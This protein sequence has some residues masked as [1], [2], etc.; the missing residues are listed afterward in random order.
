MTSHDGDTEGRDQRLDEV[1]TA[2][3]EAVD[4]GQ[5]PAP[6]E[7]LARYPDLAPEL[8]AFFAAQAHLERM[9]APHRPALRASDITADLTVAPD[10]QAIAAA[11]GTVRYFGDY[12]LL[13]EIARGG[14]GVVYRARQVSLNRTVALKMILAG[15]FASEADVRRFKTEAE[16][17]AN[18][19][20]PNIVPIYEV[21][22]YQGQHYFSMKLIEGGNLA[23]ERESA[24]A[25]LRSAARLIVAVAGAVH[26][27]HQRGIL[28]RDLKPAN[29]LIDRAG[30]PHV[31]DFG[32]AKRVEGGQDLTQSGAILG[33]PSYMAPEQAAGKRGLSTAAD[34]YSLGAILYE[35]LTGRPPF[36]ADTPLDTVLQVLHEE[37][38]RPRSLNAAVPRDLETTCL[39]CLQKDPQRRYGSAEALA[40]DLQRW[41]AGE[42][43]AARPVGRWERAR[44][45]VR[46]RP[47]AAALIAVSI[48][49]SLTLLVGGVAY[50]WRLESALADARN[51]RTQVEERELTVRGQL[52]D[53]DVRAMQEAW[54]KGNTA[55]V[56]ELLK[57]HR[58]LR[59][60]TNGQWFEQPDVRSFEWYL[61]WGLCRD[62]VLRLPCGGAR[63]VAYAPD[64]K[65]LVTAGDKLMDI[66]PKEAGAGHAL[67]CICLWNAHNGERLEV[68]GI[69]QDRVTHL[70]FSPDGKAI[71]AAIGK[72]V[73]VYGPQLRNEIA[74][75]PQPNW[76]C[77]LAFARDRPEQL[78]VALQGPKGVGGEVR[79]INLR[80]RASVSVFTDPNK[81]PQVIDLSADGATLAVGTGNR[82][83]L[84]RTAGGV[85]HRDLLFNGTHTLALS[86]DGKLLALWR[87]SATVLI[88]VATGKE[89][90]QLAIKETTWAGNNL[91]FAPDGKT[92]ALSGHTMVQLWDVESRKEKALFKGPAHAITA[93]AF[94]PDGT[95]LAAAVH[96]SDEVRIW[97]VAAPPGPESIALQNHHFP[98]LA[99]APDGKTLIVRCPKA[100]RRFR[101]MPE[102]PDS[103]L[104]FETRPPLEARRNTVNVFYATASPESY[105]LCSDSVNLR[106]VAYA[107]DGK[108]VAV[109]GDR[110]AKSVQ[111]WDAVT[112][113]S[114]QTLK[115]DTPCY[116]VAFSPD[117]KTLATLGLDR[118]VTLWNTGAWTERAV[119]AGHPRWIDGLAFTA[120]GA[121]LATAGNDGTVKL[122]DVAAGKER[123]TLPRQ[124]TRLDVLLFSPDSRV[125]VTG[126]KPDEGGG[127]I[128]LWDPATGKELGRVDG[129]YSTQQNIA[130]S[131][132]GTRLAVVAFDNMAKQYAIKLCDGRTGAVRA[133]FAAHNW[134]IPGLAF[135][136]GGKTL[137]TGSWDQT[138]KVWDVPGGKLRKSLP[139]PGWVE[140][141]A[142]SPDGATLIAGG[143][144]GTAR[145]WDTADYH[146]RAVLDKAGDQSVARLALSA[147]GAT[148][149][150]AGLNG[151]GMKAW[152]VADG[153][154]RAALAVETGAM[155]PP[156]F[157]PDGQTLVID[158][159]NTVRL[160]D[161]E[162][163]KE[164]KLPTPAQQQ[165][166]LFVLAATPD[167]HNVLS[168]RSGE[169]TATLWDA[170]AHKERARLDGFT[171]PISRAAFTRDGRLLA[172]G[173]DDG[174]INLWDG[175]TGKWQQALH[176]H[177]GS[178][179]TDLTFT[180]DGSVL[181]S[182]SWDGTIRLWDPA[183]RE[184]LVN[185]KATKGVVKLALAPTGPLLAGVEHD[186]AV[187]L[188]DR[189][190]QQY[191]GTLRKD[192]SAASGQVEAIGF[193]P[194]GRT[195]A[196]CQ[197]NVLKLW[198]PA[199]GLERL[200]LWDAQMQIR[201]FAFAPDG[202]TLAAATD[203][204]VRLWHAAS[205]READW[206]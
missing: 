156:I 115:R 76:V 133:A 12:E 47:A 62:G 166:S 106:R 17:A 195:L 82:V 72:E 169:K 42:P 27:A 180:D 148:L 37:P 157:A 61:F 53:Y 13:E 160:W 117:G 175:P 124:P 83:V 147:D 159:Y 105:T 145:L 165:H 100:S 91:T 150:T 95:R 4:A 79:L 78:A 205:A 109:A 185:L 192:P 85:N 120:D 196:T 102:R 90:G 125:L 15:Q 149:I 190:R 202:K 43:I 1:A 139:G 18:L 158:S 135:A 23:A 14:M 113:Q 118:C 130:F 63:L 48:V 189:E 64:G 58:P 123:V 55:R 11:L 67:E 179:V 129:S 22:E 69:P 57:A 206:K 10:K 86:P 35:L 75:L 6:D 56:H 187:H 65:T 28:H 173:H 199:T 31:T 3:L 177:D 74:R 24:R 92:L 66:R 126:L 112:G 97:D 54:D 176:G 41:L 29:I 71:A 127:T 52:Y 170:P 45:W 98:A 33:T 137:A 16:A 81:W 153:K 34:V 144:D 108:I 103:E 59:G 193:S 132:D 36:R 51:A 111:L 151:L 142:Y 19:D 9:T 44:L 89:L 163:W 200:T 128:T 140:C 122:W 46:R 191:R 172:T 7:W 143:R 152:D 146:E 171:A 138:V 73:V 110:A 161:A 80:T 182:T 32:L 30:A 184:S 5:A 101:E 104:W 155:S 2:Y 93:L 39:K 154:Q 198:D 203:H 99:F 60:W 168:A 20:H 136:P 188:W 40:D 178:T 114:L 181:A 88:D 21:G 131:D 84:C 38:A 70:R 186:G 201:S 194:D 183:Q 96:E 87:S 141:L 116:A 164:R 77:G 197:G 26:Y 119:L 25:D 8:N 107:T 94:S 204:E 134:V 167:G 121:T 49:A 162:T 174:M 68:S 50:H